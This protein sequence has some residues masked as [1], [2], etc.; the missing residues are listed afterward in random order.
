MNAFR[1]KGR[2]FFETKVPAL[3]DGV[4]EWVRVP[5]GTVDGRTA[6]A[7]DA[8]VA[9]L[10]PEGKHA[11]DLLETVTGKPQRWTLPQLYARWSGVSA[12]LLDEDG[13]PIQPTVKQRLLAV[14]EQLTDVDLEPMVEQFYKVMAGPSSGMSEDTAKHYRSAVRIMIPKGTSFARSALTTRDLRVWIEEM[15]DVEPGTVRKRG[16][17]MRRFTQW[18]VGRGVLG[19]DPMRD[20]TL[21]PAGD[22]LCHYL[23][24]GESERLADAQAG[25]YRLFGAV[26]P[27]SAIEVS[28][29]L[30][31]R[32]R[33]VLKD[34][35]E[36]RAA[37]TKTYNRDRI[38][39]VAD[40][41]WPAVLE[42]LKGKHPDTR[43]FDQIRDRWYARS[44]HSDA[45]TA[46]VEKGHPIY[47]TP[48]PYT[49]RDHRHT[50]AVRAAR[51][52]T[53]VEGIS[54]QLGHV[55]GIL[56]HKV[57]GRFVPSTAERDR[58]EKLATAM[59]KA[60]A[61]ARKQ[62]GAQ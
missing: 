10:G 8:M 17:G 20:I 40:W 45:V 33:D 16:A 6:K 18:L 22:P 49:L 23:D 19:A 61:V 38:V 59:D 15:D 1:R 12:G 62:G 52:G 5:C 41:A 42:L 21:P 3:R 11:W 30:A 46:L 28:V 9:T 34:S 35:R 37:G 56:A 7:M 43:L 36:I 48:K 47:A 31:L 50:W 55:N 51:S 24:T 32:V 53:P 26:L 13:D 27:G 2:R 25:Q 54:R 29:A 57:Y 60:Q 58:W 4:V 39:R 44:A 14:R